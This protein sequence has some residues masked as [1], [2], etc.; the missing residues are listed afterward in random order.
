IQSHGP[1]QLR[2]RQAPLS[3]THPAGSEIISTP[4]QVR[5][6]EEALLISARR[7][8]PAVDVL[9]ANSEVEKD[10]RNDRGLTDQV[11]TGAQMARRG[12]E[13][14]IARVG[15]RYLQPQS[16]VAWPLADLCLQKLDFADILP[17]A[18]QDI[19]LFNPFLLF[20]YGRY[21]ADLGHPVYPLSA[22]NVDQRSY[23]PAGDSPSV[24]FPR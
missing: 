11:E 1:P 6:Q 24:P 18:W 10:P 5:K 23:C 14:A 19:Q 15:L 17:L 13:V 22:R 8:P 7:F 3:K 20:Y 21:R 12:V 2:D 4:E 9:Q 16:P